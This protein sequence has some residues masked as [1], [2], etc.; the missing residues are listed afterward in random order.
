M[1]APAAPG[2]AR[3]LHNPQPPLRGR[4]DPATVNSLVILLGLEAWKPVLTA[5]VLPP[6]PLLLLVLIGARTMLPRRGLGWLIILVAV[7]LL[8]LSNCSGSARLLTQFV[9][10]PPAALTPARL[11]ALK[12]ESKAT[13]AIV[14][15]GGGTEPL[16]P[17]YGTSN[18][19]HASL[20]RLRYGLWLARETGLP[21]AFS[22]G[23]G[24][25]QPDGPAEAQVA[26]RIAANEFSRPLKW[27]EDNSRD[28]REN[29]IRSVALLRRAGI[30][31]IVLV[32]H[33]VHMPRAM[34]DFEQVAGED[35]RIEAAPMGGARSLER[36]VL[37]WLPSADGATDVRDILR[38]LLGRALGA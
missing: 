21:V 7:V 11:Q 37:K 27:I 10:R 38:E 1:S 9:L 28:T 35:V 4:P 33:A 31:H 12:A 32:T 13:T 20:E 19:Y 18:L 34:A 24:W 6:T 23:M 3:L 5:L 30:R 2:A 17:E 16:A 29:A 15:L 36:P 14:V 26:A 25:S 8:W 22:G